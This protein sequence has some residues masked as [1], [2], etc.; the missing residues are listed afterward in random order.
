MTGEMTIKDLADS[1]PTPKESLAYGM[2][3]G[4][5]I[6]WRNIMV[7]IVSIAM[8]I[9]IVYLIYNIQYLKIDM[10]PLQYCSYLMNKSSCYCSEKLAYSVAG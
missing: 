6:D 1:N 4:Q 5:R 2:T 9:L 8:L 10:N 3:L 7:W